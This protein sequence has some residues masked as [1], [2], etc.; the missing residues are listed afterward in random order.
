MADAAGINVEKVNDFFRAS[1]PGRRDMSNDDVRLIIEKM[2]ETGYAHRRRG[3]LRRKTVLFELPRTW[4]HDKPMAGAVT[5]SQVAENTLYGSVIGALAR[6]AGAEEARLEIVTNLSD[7]TWPRA[8]PEGE[9]W[10]QL[11]RRYSATTAAWQLA[12]IVA[13][14]PK[15][16]AGI[17][18]IDP[19]EDDPRLE[20]L[21]GQQVP[22][23]VMGRAPGRLADG[24]VV[25][26]DD[27]AGFEMLARYVRG[28]GVE[29]SEVG[30]VRFRDD[31]TGPPARRRTGLLR[32]LAITET[33]IAHHRALGRGMDAN[34]IDIDY[35]DT[36]QAE[37]VKHLKDWLE[38]NEWSAVVADCDRFASYT[39]KA[40]AQLG[41][42]VSSTPGEGRIVLA[43]CD[44]SVE[45]HAA[46]APWATL[47]QPVHEWAI[48]V[49]DCLKKQNRKGWSNLEPTLI[50]PVL[51]VD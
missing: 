9:E 8:L 13:Q 6:A 12:D 16:F 1:R 51:V 47:R 20:W 21:S 35:H 48:K 44:D 7:L 2:I 39:A 45:R 50:E 38:A 46:P 30:H 32:G 49:I 41:L 33:A 40:A 4:V 18:I 15:S 34:S 28:L 37:L 10:V 19:G 27:E 31:R 25:D 29:S 36:D 14:R 23:V 3:A 42:A 26:I 22:Y 5:S 43:G 11:R 17:V 24:H